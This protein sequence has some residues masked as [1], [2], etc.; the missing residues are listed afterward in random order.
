MYRSL[1]HSHNA[2]PGDFL[3]WATLAE[4]AA[5]QTEEWMA[6]LQHQASTCSNIIIIMIKMMM[7]TIVIILIIIVRTIITDMLGIQIALTLQCNSLCQCQVALQ[8]YA[9]KWKKMLGSL[10][11]A[12]GL[13]LRPKDVISTLW[14]KVIS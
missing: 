13:L 9:A 11:K 12:V 8:G 14:I 2:K 7:I 5:Q 6:Q 4:K 1:H 10:F 3:T